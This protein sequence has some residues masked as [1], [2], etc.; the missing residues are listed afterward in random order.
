[1]AK[2]AVDTAGEFERT[3]S[4]TGIAARVVALRRL[5]RSRETADWVAATVK[6]WT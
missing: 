2:R 1:M 4:V 5:S 3:P 6:W